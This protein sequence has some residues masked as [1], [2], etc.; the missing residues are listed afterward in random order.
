MTQDMEAYLLQNE[1]ITTQF[2]IKIM[3]FGEMTIFKFDQSYV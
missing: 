2:M 3:F 1:P